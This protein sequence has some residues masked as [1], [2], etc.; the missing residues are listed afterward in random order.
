VRGGPRNAYIEWRANPE[1][2]IEGYNVYRQEVAGVEDLTEVGE[3]VKINGENPIAKTEYI[4]RGIQKDRFYCYSV[5]AVGADGALSER[6]D[7]SMPPLNG[8]WLRVYFPDIYAS[9][10]GIYGFHDDD[11]SSFKIAIPIATQC[12]Y[13]LSTCAIQV[14]VHLPRALMDGAEED[15]DV[16]SSGIM[17]GFI[18]M[19]NV[20][21]FDD[22]TVELR[23]T[24][25]GLT[26]LPLYGAG[27]LFY[28]VVKPSD[29]LLAGNDLCGSLSFI[30][31]A[32]F[33]SGVRL[34]DG[35]LKPVNLDLR[36]GRLCNRGLCAVHGDANLDGEITAADADYILRIAAGEVANPDACTSVVGDI[37]MDGALDQA[38]A[39]LLLRRL[40]IHDLWPE[41]ISKA[42]GAPDS[43]AVPR[44]D[45]SDGPLIRVGD[46]VADTG[47][48]I[49]VPVYVENAPQ[50]AGGSFDIT[51][52]A[53]DHGLTF[54]S[55]ELGE[56]LADAGFILAEAS[57]HSPSADDKG[58]VHIAIAGSGAIA[59]KEPTVVA[60]LKFIAAKSGSMTVPIR[61][62]DAALTD[63]YGFTPRY[64]APNAPSS[65]S[66]S[67][68]ING[69]ISGAM[70]V[71]VLDK[72]AQTPITNA[73]VYVLPGPASPVTLN[74]NGIYTFPSLDPGNHEFTAH[75][76][77]YISGKKTGF[78]PSG[79]TG[80][81][82]IELAA[83]V[84]EGEGEGEG[85]CTSGTL[86]SRPPSNTRGSSADAAILLLLAL[87]LA[88]R[89]P[90]P[91]KRLRA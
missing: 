6:S 73:Q 47:S 56:E 4:D 2:D 64:D 11:D 8:R 30:R 19:R 17:A 86:A 12:A 41:P 46:V 80:T 91:G 89:R 35:S 39:V 88:F 76:P 22:E 52:P 51:F 14:I 77:D 29:A 36:D 24:A 60:V 61:T 3:A 10:A 75:A 59:T 50:A 49:E 54:Q 42:D 71:L 72:T 1:Y 37:N 16:Y 66:G 21:A 53:G 31:D 25:A 38:D 9:Q 23:I 27:T 79:G 15:I 83:G 5:E 26:G 55:A 20:F 34:Y 32:E 28:I 82:T 90:S 48:L 40:Q 63:T 85:D 57:G 7:L 69:M 33:L 62:S 74:N 18:S 87:A 67:V 78:V 13:D 84:G 68:Q 58:F 70:A 65:A 81:M 44:K 45:G 43:F